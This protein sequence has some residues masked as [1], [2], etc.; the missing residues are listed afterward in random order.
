MLEKNLDK[1]NWHCLSQNPNAI[2]LLENNI[3]KIIWFWLS[4]NINAI[5]LL[6]KNLDKVKW[7]CL[8]QNPNIF[9]YDYETMKKNCSIFKEEL[10]KKVWSPLRV[11]K[12]LE[13]GFDLDE[14]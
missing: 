3:N 7:H 9:T 6:E 4:F 5:Y 14:L 10:I 8:S 13:T 11:R 12:W 2:H 1:V